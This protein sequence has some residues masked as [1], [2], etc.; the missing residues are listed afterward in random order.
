MKRVLFIDF[1]GTLC[2]EKLWRSLPPKQH[3]EIQELFFRNNAQMVRDWMRGKYT[4]EEINEY[5]AQIMNIPYQDLW[6]LF[7]DDCK[8]MSVSL[9]ILS[10]INKLRQKF[11]VV[12]M[13]GN[14]DCFMRFTV[15]AL[16]LD[17]Y[18]DLISSSYDE[19]KHKTDN[20]GE[21]FVEYAEKFNSKMCDCVLID[22]NEKCCD[23]FTGHGGEAFKVSS[24][25]ETQVILSNL[26]H[27]ND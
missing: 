16:Q 20:Y 13:T 14:M 19:G 23:L 10:V 18:F 1:D 5:A 22:D 12:L 21:L 9:D 2:N 4:A 3:E 7:V 17:N 25:S 27:N 15:P 11:T 26:M 8:T 6:N 24:I